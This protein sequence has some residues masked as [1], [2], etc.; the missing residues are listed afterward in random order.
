MQDDLLVVGLDLET[1][2]E[3]HVA[4]RSMEY[5]RA[6]GYS[7]TR[8]LVCF[9]CFHGF[10]APMGTRV[11]LVVRGR[12]GGRV[13][14]H[15]A[16]PAGKAPDGGHHP[17][18]VWHLTAK[19]TLARWARGLPTVAAV[20]L[21]QWTP[22]HDRRADVAVRLHDGTCIALEAQ[23]ELMTD[24]AW[25]RRHHDYAR[26]GIRDVWLW[27]PG[28]HVPHVVLGEGLPVWFY[29]PSS[30]QIGTAFGRPH[31]RR[32]RWWEAEDLTVF[33]LH[34]PPCP[35]DELDRHRLPLAALGLD[36]HGAVL[37]EGM[38][39]SLHDSQQKVRQEAA[40]RRESEARYARQLRHVQQRRTAD[41]RPAP[42]PAP[43]GGLRCTV[44]KR[45]LA[46]ELAK[47]GRHILC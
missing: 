20:R 34:H 12:L 32:H 47:A 35:Q 28:L 26:A 14:P 21:E 27:R 41:S 4:E 10:E 29:A 46:S 23:R 37:P 25:H 30:G 31:I 44:C 5:W 43:P 39:K 15:F 45:P 33:A 24:D 17:E 38:W 1:G 40:Q 7:G 13:R 19:H 36:L 3:V 11:P 8:T 2:H 6:R 16:H 42:P 18:T 22:S 9:Y